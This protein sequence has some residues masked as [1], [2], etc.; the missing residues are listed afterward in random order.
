MPQNNTPQVLKKGDLIKDKK[1]RAIY[2]VTK[3]KGSRVIVKYHKTLKNKKNIKIPEEYFPLQDEN[4][5][6]D[7]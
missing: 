6:S 1:G 2:K 4:D 3:V 7:M 5:L